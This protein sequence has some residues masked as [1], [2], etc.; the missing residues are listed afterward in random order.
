[1]GGLGG[2]K[3][4]PP[5]FCEFFFNIIIYK[6]KKVVA[7][8]I[9]SLEF[10]E[11]EKPYL[12]WLIT[13]WQRNKPSSQTH[14]LQIYKCMCINMWHPEVGMA[15]NLLCTLHAVSNTCLRP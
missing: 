7:W 5:Q 15:K 6:E 1:M 10:F 2:L 9:F 11:S 4:P 3:P 12:L 14:P 13:C 8:V